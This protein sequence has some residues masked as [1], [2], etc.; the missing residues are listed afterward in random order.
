LEHEY[1]VD[2]AMY[3]PNGDLIASACADTAVRLWD[4]GTGECRN[5]FIGH[6]KW[7]LRAMFSP[8]G[9]LVASACGDNT[10]RLWDVASG[11]CRAVIR[12][13][14]GSVNDVAWT[15]I[16]DV[17]YLV[18]GDQEGS[19]RAWEL[20]EEG[21]MYRVKLRWGSMNTV[22]AV[23]NTT[24][25]GVQGLSQVNERLLKQRGAVGEP[26]S[27]LREASKKVTALASVVS[28]LKA[29]SSGTVE[30][31]IPAAGVSVEQL[32]YRA[33]RAKDPLLRELLAAVVRD[34]HG[35]K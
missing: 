11:R 24:I 14:G 31:H 7:V 32:E 23:V 35:S 16:S 6:S 20:T 21:D 8:Q 30:G 3:S 5:I 26:A 29:V 33:E 2:F 13:F 27:I 12:E 25:Q 17:N 22:L 10:V 18:T 4:A 28:K 9:D 19:V 15:R 34:I 1:F